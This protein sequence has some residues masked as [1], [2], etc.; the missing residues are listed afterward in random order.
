MGLGVRNASF[1]NIF[2]SLYVL[3]RNSLIVTFTAVRWLVSSFSL[4][5]VD[6][7]GRQNTLGAL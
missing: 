4:C 1:G 2:D 6:C 3:S 5:Q 7:S